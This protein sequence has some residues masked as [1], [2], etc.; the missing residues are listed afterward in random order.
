MPTAG[1]ASATKVLVMQSKATPTAAAAPTPGPIHTSA[2]ITPKLQ[3]KPQ[4]IRRSTGMPLRANRGV[5]KPHNQKVTSMAR[6]IKNSP[7]A[8]SAA[9]QPATCVIQG[10]AHKVWMATMPP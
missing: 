2:P 3:G 10:P 8:A 6:L 7:D 9:V 5:I 4:A 1:W